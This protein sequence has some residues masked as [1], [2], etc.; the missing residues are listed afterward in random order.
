MGIPQGLASVQLLAPTTTNTGAAS[1]AVNTKNALRV[2]VVVEL[3][4]AVG[5]ATAISL[6]QSSTIALGSTAAG[7]SVPNWLN[8]DCAASDALTRGTD[9]AAVTVTND[10]KS[11]QIVFQVDPVKLTA[12]KP[13]VY[14]TAADSS[15]AT[16]LMSVTAYVE[17][18]YAGDAPPSHVVD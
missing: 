9:A 16:N 18:R 15:Q 5:H 1:R 4:Q 3:K 8:E 17:P 14:V 7:P 13:C 10:V 11:K 2:Y 6:R 12:G